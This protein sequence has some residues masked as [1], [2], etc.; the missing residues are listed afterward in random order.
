MRIAFFG[1]PEF[2]VPSLQAIL[3][4]GYEVATVITRP[5]RPRG[6]SRS[7]LVPSPLKETAQDLG[8]PLLQPE[9]PSGDVFQETLR[10]LDLDLGVVVAYGHV[11]R[12]EV[13]GIP[14]L[15]MIN[16]HASLLPK[17]RGAAPIEWAI[18][19]GDHET[20]VTIMQMEAGLDSGPVLLTDSTPIGKTE[21]KG[22]LRSRLSE[23]GAVALNEVL[24]KADGSVL[25]GTPQD[26]A[27]AT[28]A[29]KIDRELCR[30][31]WTDTAE[32]CTRRIRAFD[33][34]PGAWTELDG[35]TVKL[36]D[37]R[38]AFDETGSAPPGTIMRVGER[39]VIAAGEGCVL[40][41][42]VQSAGKHRMRVGDWVRGHTGLE[43]RS[44]T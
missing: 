10:R 3:K 22:E 16:V 11:L 37:T 36:F 26:D 12:P 21:T 17:L 5:D 8:L 35:E 30:L 13:L 41:R 34:E 32:A 27:L 6:R 25:K 4:A 7:R 44:F 1:T 24:G 19:N 9:R 15:G 20:G 33:P 31:M 43:G 40:V 29:P 39:L 23:I 28:H 2:A 14:R 38:E 18:L 42:E